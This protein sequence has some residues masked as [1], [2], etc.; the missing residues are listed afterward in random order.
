VKITN[1]YTLNN[2]ANFGGLKRESVDKDDSINY[3]FYIPKTASSDVQIEFVHLRKDPETNKYKQ[4]GL[5]KKFS[6][7]DE[8]D[9]AFK[10]ITLNVSND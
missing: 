9:S 4:I 7:K 3:K 8:K 5:P 2:K 6:L 10:S 1:N